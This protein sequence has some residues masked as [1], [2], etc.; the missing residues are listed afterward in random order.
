[1]CTK[2]VVCPLQVSIFSVRQS[3]WHAVSDQCVV[4]S[5]PAAPL[6]GH[7]G[8]TGWRPSLGKL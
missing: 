3:D 6:H 4:R 1:M 5:A 7:G 8:T 2:A